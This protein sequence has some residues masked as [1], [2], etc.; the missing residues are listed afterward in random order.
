[1]RRGFDEFFPK[2]F[3]GGFAG[4]RKI[5][6]KIESNRGAH[7]QT[8]VLLL[9]EA[10]KTQTIWEVFLSA[11]EVFQSVNAK[12]SFFLAERLKKTGRE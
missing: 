1:M 5:E 12:R 10:L 11:L 9:G 2:F 4:P 8:M 6:E 3:E 7:T